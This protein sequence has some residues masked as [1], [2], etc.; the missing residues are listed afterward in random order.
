VAVNQLVSFVKSGAVAYVLKTFRLWH[1]NHN[2]RDRG[3]LT[4]P[5]ASWGASTVT[6]KVDFAVPRQRDEPIIGELQLSDL[7]G[8]VG[9]PGPRRL[10]TQVRH[11]LQSP[12]EHDAV[13][14][15]RDMSPGPVSRVVEITPCLP[16]LPRQKRC[17]RSNWV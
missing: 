9:A 10:R 2:K 4:S 17:A 14:A 16:Q 1:T 6:Q 11:D 12:G 8:Q 5:R 3:Y 13:P 15:A 7:D